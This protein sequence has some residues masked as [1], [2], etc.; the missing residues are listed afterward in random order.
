[1]ERKIIE[2]IIEQSIQKNLK[3][4][5][6]RTTLDSKDNEL[7]EEFETYEANRE[8]KEHF[9]TE[10]YKRYDLYDE[11]EELQ[12]EHKYT[13]EQK[14]IVEKWGGSAYMK[15]NG[16]IYNT[17]YYQRRRKNGSLDDEDIRKINKNIEILQSAID[18]SPRVP[19]NVMTVRD[20]HWESGHKRGD[21]IVQKGFAST[22]Y[23][24]GVDASDTDEDNLY[25]IHYYIPKGTKG[26]LLSPNQFDVLP[27]DELLLGQNTRQYVLKQDDYEQTVKILVLPDR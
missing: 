3:I 4:K 17:P 8:I 18:D 12:S 16:K 11:H 22:S 10:I 6:G 5:C 21:V 25:S 23:T 1:M 15:I 20:G 2:K 26:L 24:S 14:D 13:E 27:E 7:I 19:H 9:A